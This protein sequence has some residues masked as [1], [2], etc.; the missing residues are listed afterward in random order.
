ML[1]IRVEVHV[2]KSPAIVNTCPWT[3][4][5]HTPTALLIQDM[6][7]FGRLK[8]GQTIQLNDNRTGLIRFLGETAFK[9]GDWVGI[10]L[11]EPLGKNDG[12]VAG[13]RY[14]D[15]ETQHGVFARA[16]GIAII[17]EEPTPKPTTKAA[18]LRTKTATGLSK[19][20]PSQNASRRQTAIDPNAAKRRS[21]NSASPTPSAR[22]Q[23]LTNGTK[24][25]G[26]ATHSR[27]IVLTITASLEACF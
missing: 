13:E 4:C 14:F 2:N 12:S 10:D 5:S 1:Q 25:K 6:T 8:I 24:V 23:T 18:A 15:C 21:M 9:E 27:A 19:P 26:L 16:T 20:Q 3:R 11:D 7:D 22:R 17:L